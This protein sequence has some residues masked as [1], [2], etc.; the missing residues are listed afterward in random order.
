MLHEYMVI[1]S[2]GRLEGKVDLEGAKN[3]VLVIMTSLILA[4]GKSTLRRVPLSSDFF[5][6]AGLL[7]SLGA[8]VVLDE[9]EKVVIIDTSNLS[10]L[11]VGPEIMQKMRASILVMGPLLA[12]FGSAEVALPG[13]CVLGARPIDFHLRALTKMGAQTE[14]KGD[15]LKVS[16]PKLVAQRFVLEYP[17]VGAT[18]NI[19]MAAVLTQGVTEIINAAIEPEVLDLIEVLQ[20]MGAH[21]EL[22]VPGTIRIEGVQALR[23]VEHTIMTD[24][25]EAGTLMLAAA[26][27]G[28]SLRIPDAPVM[29]ME[30]F[31]EKLLEMG[32]KISLEGAGLYFEATQTPRAVSF[33]TMPY[34]GFPTDLQAPMMVAQARAQGTSVIYETVFEN[35][36][37][38]IRELQKMGAQITANGP[39]IA[40][41]TGVDA[42]FGAQV[43]APDI[44]A[45]AALVIAGLAAEGQTIMSGLHHF[46]RGYPNLDVKLRSLGARISIVSDPQASV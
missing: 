39:L 11:P 4:P 32:H 1:E 20:K 24:R 35:R 23:P 5:L 12:R 34:P 18:E 46:R 3:A 31:L 22:A 42:L 14:I 30:L 41:V 33:K 27:T 21:I 25:L 29:Y 45:S 28:G 19:L 10:S 26:V 17:S 15:F 2:A 37:M 6:M 40:T 9:A 43:I 16:A 38:H 44:R 36:L 8:S 13:G 7:E